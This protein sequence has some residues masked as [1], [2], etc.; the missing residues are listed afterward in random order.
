MSGKKRKEEEEGGRPSSFSPFTL[1]PRPRSRAPRFRFFITSSSSFSFKTFP[2]CPFHRR[3]RRRRATPRGEI[4]PPLLRGLSNPRRK[5]RKDSHF[6]PP[7]QEDAG[8][9]ENFHHCIRWKRRRERESHPR[10]PCKSEG[11]ERKP[12]TRREGKD[13]GEEGGWLGVGGGMTLTPARRT[14]TQL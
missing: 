11:R 10:P 1:R 9:G 8:G 14:L 4:A 2:R 3:R 12:F 13:M 6:H 5:G 7:L